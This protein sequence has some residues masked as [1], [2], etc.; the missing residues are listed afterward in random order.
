MSIFPPINEQMDFIRRGVEEIISEDELVK[1]FETAE[2]T[3]D[4]LVIKLGCDPS[5]P[6]L[7]IGHAVVLRKLRHFQDI[8]HQSVLVIGDFTALIGDPSGRNKTRPQL[9]PEQVDEFA[10]AY[11]QQA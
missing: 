3:G 8:G 11:V 6:D 9:T 2:K 4:P 10:E 1:K 7:H 5:R